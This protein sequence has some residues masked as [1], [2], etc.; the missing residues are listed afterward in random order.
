M[1]SPDN[2]L[3][4]LKNLCSSN[5]I[6]EAILILIFE[7]L[8]SKIGNFRT[9]NTKK[10]LN[11]NEI[12]Y[13]IGLWAKNKNN[14][15]ENNL[16]PNE[17]AIRCE[18]LLN[19][20]HK[21]YLN[22]APQLDPDKSTSEMFMNSISA[23][24]T[25]FYS[26]TGGYDYQFAYFFKDVYL[27]DRKWILENK[28]FSINS[29]LDFFIFFK[30]VFNYS[31]NVNYGGQYS[32]Q[33]FYYSK[34]SYIFKK[35]PE[36]K[37]I[38]SLISIN[39]NV[40]VNSNFEHFGDFNE[41]RAKP[42]I[43][44][45]DFY[46]IPIPFLISEAL[47][48]APYYW[49][50]QDTNYKAIALKNRGNA[51]E[52][53]V[54]KLLRNKFNDADIYSNVFV[55]PSRRKILT[56]L[57]VCI[58]HKTTLIIFQVKSKKLTQLSKRGNVDQLKRDFKL[59]VSDAYKQAK[60]SYQPIINNETKL[61]DQKGKL[62]IDPVGIKEIYSVCTLLDYYPSVK[63]H[64][65]FNFF[66][67]DEIPIAI[68]IFHLEIILEFMSNLEM[69][70]DYIKQRVKYSKKIVADSELS[71]LKCYLEQGLTP[72]QGEDVTMLDVSYAQQF[73]SD[74]YMNLMFKYERKLP[75]F[76]KGIGRNDGC[77]CGLP[78]K[79]KFCCNN[80]K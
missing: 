65:L 44:Y 55:K 66:D 59:A 61:V 13:L 42:I 72:R 10:L 45:L 73:D 5:N 79:Y 50:L 43:E 17:L 46:L 26:G 4:E 2:I 7:N 53:I 38:I 41:Y 24:E 20:L 63:S 39:A 16:G 23:I 80:K 49:F 76:F 3:T 57:D 29:V 6:L 70:I 71:Y 12:T 75:L 52:R 54:T 35:Y 15:V 48:E 28:G 51:A 60:V 78:K 32:S 33:A 22:S 31:I 62:L 21:S 1:N 56:E 30:S 27:F 18:D 67:S 77:F 14:L 36:F 69:F 19:D 8:N 9:R 37:K 40:K 64:T 11:T 74:Y 58:K 68:S 34:N 47:F 25:T